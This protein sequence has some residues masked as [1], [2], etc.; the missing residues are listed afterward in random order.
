MSYIVF[1]VTLAAAVVLAL[2][3]TWVLLGIREEAA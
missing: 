1:V 2:G 3:I